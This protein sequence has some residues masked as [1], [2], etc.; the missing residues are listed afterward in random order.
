MSDTTPPPPTSPPPPPPAPPPNPEPTKKP[1]Y[2]RWWGITLIAIFGLALLSNLTEG[3]GDGDR[4]ADSLEE[5]SSPSETLTQAA[6]DEPSP[7]AEPTR[8]SSSPTADVPETTE[9]A[10]PPSPSPE[11]A[12][13][14]AGPAFATISLAGSGDDVVN[15]PG[16][17]AGALAVATFTHQGGAN[18]SVQA[19]GPDTEDD[20]G[21]L[22]VN[23][24]GSYTGTVPINFPAQLTTQVTD[25]DITADGAWTIDIRPL[26]QA[27]SLSLPMDS[28]TGDEVLIATEGISG[29]FG[30]THAG[31]ANFVVQGYGDNDFPD[32]LINEIGS[33]EG[34]VRVAGGTLV[35][36]ITADGE[37]TITQ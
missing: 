34:R 19:F 15:V 9:S 4:L 14:S 17:P 7:S 29:P 12:P 8:E 22:L 21:E 10:P 37:W 6:S 11:P 36:T 20:F 13:E 25:F 23:E 28:G 31:T 26:S 30:F 33:Y 3:S 27:R 18:F 35:L 24:I 2:R 16:L 5:T 1:W 32:L